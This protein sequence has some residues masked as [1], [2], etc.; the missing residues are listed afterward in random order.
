MP[1]ARPRVG[2]AALRARAARR[3]RVRLVVLPLFVVAV[4]VAALVTVKLAASADGPRSGQRGGLAAPALV[5]ALRDVPPGVAAHVGAGTSGPPTGASLTAITGSPLGS[6]AKPEVLYVGAEYCPYCAAQRWAMA[7]ALLRFGTFTGLGTT[8]SAR[9]DGDIA[10]LSFHGARYTSR[11]LSFVGKETTTNQVVDGHYAAL[12]RLNAA[13]QALL[14]RYDAPP[15]VPDGEAGSIPF[16]DLGGRYVL[17]GAQYPFTVLRG[18]SRA[19]ITAALAD[20]ASPI[21]R[22]V[23]GAANVLTA[24]LCRLTGGEPRPVCTAAGARSAASGLP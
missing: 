24:A 12:D 11:Y 20:P 9:S 14:S 15:Y 6:A 16:V 3:Q 4:V 21:A 2:V 7:V 1:A 8:T 10:T 23:V 13:Q 5:A 22:G 19:Q 18:K 17:N